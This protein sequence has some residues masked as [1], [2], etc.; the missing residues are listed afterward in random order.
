MTKI[1]LNRFRLWLSTWLE[2]HPDGFGGD[3]HNGVFRINRVR[4][5][6]SD[7]KSNG[8]LKYFERSSVFLLA[9][10]YPTVP[11]I[12]LEKFCATVLSM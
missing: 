6:N 10:I 4:R 5:V 1:N 9:L 11:T 7:V 12:S 2:L 8:P 3:L